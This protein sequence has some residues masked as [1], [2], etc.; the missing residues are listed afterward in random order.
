MNRE[1][2][3]CIKLEK[4]NLEAKCRLQGLEK[5][6]IRRF[7]S[8]RRLK[9][10]S[11]SVEASR[12]SRRISLSKSRGVAAMQEWL[13]WLYSNVSPDYGVDLNTAYVP[14]ITFQKPPRAVPRVCHCG[15]IA[16]EM[17]QCK[18]DSE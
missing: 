9:G 15:L 2:I 13:W 3:T 17:K 1:L 7:F 16:D 10:I 11:E 12:I 8:G 4:A 6:F 5:S 18:F 14:Q